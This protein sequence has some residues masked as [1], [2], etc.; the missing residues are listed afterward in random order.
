MSWTVEEAINWIHSTLKF[1]IK[2]GLKRMEWLME[3]LDQP[4]L[5]KPVVHIAGTNGKG[6]TLNY[7]RSIL[8]ESGLTVGTFTSPYFLYFQE[9]ISVNGEMI[10]DEDLVKAVSIIKPLAEELGDTELGYPTE[11]EII[12]AIAFYYF[13]SREDIDLLL[14]EVGLGGRLDST[15]IVEPI[16]SVITTIGFDHQAI[17]GDTIEEIAREKA[18]IIK[19]G[20]PVVLGN[21]EGAAKTEILLVSE[22]MN[23]TTLLNDTWKVEQISSS[24]LG[25]EFLYIKS[26]E[27]FPVKIPLLGIHQMEN[28]GLAITAV[29]QLPY[30][31]TPSQIQSGLENARWAGRTDIVFTSPDI[32]LDGAHNKEGMTALVNAVQTVYPNKKVKVLIALLKDKPIKEMFKEL[33]KINNVEVYV[34]EFDFPRAAS[35]KEVA[36]LM[37]DNK[38]YVQ[39]VMDWKALLNDWIENN[40]ED[41]LVVTGSLYFIP[42]VRKYLQ[43]EKF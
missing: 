43:S 16:L 28:A 34:T 30:H 12:T 23:S 13:A 35:A 32:I 9:R 33:V 37:K 41:L 36:Q 40:K 3:R 19:S 2:P 31:I 26:N 6:S 25:E 8:Q 11:F 17:L 22:K 10:A 24:S 39:P 38:I 14:I 27:S 15:N 18:G 1:G 20:V 29:L 42:E 7:M 21:I 5:K 4:H